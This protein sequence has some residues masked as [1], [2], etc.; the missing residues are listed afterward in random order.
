MTYIST[1]WK[2]PVV[3]LPRLC[4]LG[5]PW[6]STAWLLLPCCCANQQRINLQLL[7]SF[8]SFPTCSLP[9]LG[10]VNSETSRKVWKDMFFP[11]VHQETDK[12]CCHFLTSALIEALSSPRKHFSRWGR[13]FLK[14]QITL[15]RNIWNSVGKK[16]HNSISF[17][18]I[19]AN[20][21]A[22]V[23]IGI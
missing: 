7:A 5:Q 19:K 2:A 23:V 15:P 9:A 6:E 22:Q 12:I 14:P 4:P 1:T 18:G 11:G 20:R 8:P 21:D 10:S 13:R 17:Q 16:M 3:E